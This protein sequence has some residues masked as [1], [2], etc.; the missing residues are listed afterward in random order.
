MLERDTVTKKN[1]ESQKREF[2]MTEEIPIFFQIFIAIYLYW[3][4][5]VAA[6]IPGIYYPMTKIF[7]FPLASNKPQEFVIMAKPEKVVV[8][9]VSN[10]LHPFFAFK[11][12]LYWFSSPCSDVENFNQYHVYI[13]GI[14]QD[15]TNMNERRESKLDDIIQ[16]DSK[17]KQVTSHTIR[18][19]L[20]I[21][22]HFHRHYALTIDPVK[23]IAVL[24][25]T[26]NAQPFKLSFY[27]TLG[28]YL[29]T[30]EQVEKEIEGSASGGQNLTQLTNQT[31]VQQI[32]YVQNYTYFSSSSAFN[33]WKKRKLIDSLYVTWLKGSQDPKLMAALILAMA[34]VAVVFIMMFGLG[35]S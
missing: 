25:K 4:V 23:K 22:D 1:Q 29:Q 7:A 10:R 32:K 24:T 15:V 21:K 3:Y 9:K 28:I 31:V 17:E 12:G 11:K 14:N 6:F 8:K 18:L 2:D 35:G 5:V 19:P 13:E 27:H 20:K 26:R 30:E 33:L 34:G 16:N